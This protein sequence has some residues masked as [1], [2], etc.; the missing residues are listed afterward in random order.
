LVGPLPWQVKLEPTPAK[1]KNKIQPAPAKDK[2]KPPPPKVKVKP[3]GKPGKGKIKQAAVTIQEGRLAK[4][5]QSK[6]TDEEI[7]EEL[8]LATLTRFPTSA[9]REHFVKYREAKKVRSAVAAIDLP[10]KK[11]FKG[12]LLNEREALFVDVL[13]ALINTREFVLNH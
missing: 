10:K 4:L 11:K 9:E 7:F 6:K 2:T 13:W 3:K 12:P 5:L 1:G 8:F